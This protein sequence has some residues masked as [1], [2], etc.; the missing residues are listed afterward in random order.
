MDIS[1]RALA[2]LLL[3]TMVVSLG[4]TILS[5]D[6]LGALSA[7]GWTTA[8]G[9][10]NLTVDTELSITTADNNEM[11]FGTCNPDTD[12]DLTVNS[13]NQGDV[14][15][16]DCPGE[17]LTPIWVRNDGNVPAVVT[18][19][20]NDWGQAGE[21]GG[22]FLPSSAG[23]SELRYKA[24]NDGSDLDTDY[25]GGCAAG[26]VDSY[27]LINDSSSYD[28]CDNL[29]YQ[30]E[31]NSVGIHFEIVI[32]RAADPVPSSATITFTAANV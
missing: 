32:P 26:L 19:E 15:E 3:A 17:E 16:A 20:S 8:A 25:S 29:G 12:S 9:Q 30:N 10:V 1:N 28:V 6:R 4:G 13:E 27:S 2:V 22:S 18:L 7:T 14:G 24:I 5:L 21:A 31:N 23:T 11:D